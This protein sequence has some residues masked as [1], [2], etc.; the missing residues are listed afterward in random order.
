V[1]VVADSCQDGNFWCRNDRFHLDLQRDLVENFCGAGRNISCFNS[2]RLEWRLL[3]DAPTKA[4]SGF[5]LYDGIRF[6]W[7]CRYEINNNDT[8]NNNK[9]N[10]GLRRTTGS[11]FLEHDCIIL[12][13]LRCSGTHCC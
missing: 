1:Q 9:L 7:F 3:D 13:P 5:D 2:R 8:D 4:A 12:S 10:P 11:A 6:H